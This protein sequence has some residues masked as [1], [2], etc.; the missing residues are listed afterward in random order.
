MILYI[1]GP[2]GY[3]QGMMN[4]PDD[5]DEVNGIPYSTTKRSIPEQMT[6]GQY[7]I[8]NGS[9]WDLTNSAPPAPFQPQYFIKVS[10]FYDRFGPSKYDIL[11][12]TDEE[13]QQ[14]IT[15]SRT[16]GYINLED[17]ELIRIV[18]TLL[19][20]NFSFDIDKVLSLDIL[21]EEKYS[22]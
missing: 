16:L 4:Y 12:S 7:A 5:P 6:E 15:T 9:G 21:E 18:N 11:F 19:E 2:D 10:S 20:K 14:Y 22:P 17:S 13:V 3:Y 8:W 1:I